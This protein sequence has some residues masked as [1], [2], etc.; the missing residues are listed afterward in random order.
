MLI[1]R[2][3]PPSELVYLQNYYLINGLKFNIPCD[4]SRVLASRLVVV[5]GPGFQP[6]PRPIKV[7]LSFYIFPLD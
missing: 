4:V 2:V 1:L 5:S 3:Q 7:S 6:G